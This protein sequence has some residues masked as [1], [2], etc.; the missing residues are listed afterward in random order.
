MPFIMPLFSTGYTYD[1]FTTL[2]KYQKGMY[3]ALK[4]TI[5]AEKEKLP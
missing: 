5:I 4:V 3:M 1:L 2:E